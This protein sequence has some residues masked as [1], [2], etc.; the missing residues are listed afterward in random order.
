MK[1]CYLNLL[2]ILVIVSC[3]LTACEN[4]SGSDYLAVKITGD[5]NWSILDVNS[6]EFIYRDE[7]KNCPSVIVDNLFFVEKDKGNGY[8]CYNVTN[9]SNPINKEAYVYASNFRDGVA[10]VLKKG[11]PISIINAMGQEVK[12]LDKKIVNVFP[13]N[14]GFS[15]VI[16]KDGK[17]GVI[18]TKG[19]WAIKADYEGIIPFSQDGFAVTMK[20]QNDTLYNYSI[21]DAHGQKYYS[22]S[23]EK[24]EP[25]GSIVNGSM[26]VRKDNRVIYIDKNGERILE[27]G[28]FFKGSEISYGMYNGVTVYASNDAKMGLMNEKGEKLIRDKYDFI[29]PQKDGKFIVFRDGKCGLIDKDDN[30]I[31]PID[32][33]NIQKLK[34]NRYVVREGENKYSLI[35]E[36]GNE[37]CKETLASISLYKEAPVIF[38]ANTRM[39]TFVEEEILDM[40]R[41]FD[42]MMDELEIE[43]GEVPDDYESLPDVEEDKANE[44]LSALGTLR[45]KGIVDRYPITIEFT[46]KGSQVTGNLYYDRQ[47]PSNRLYFKGTNRNGIVDL[48]ETDDQSNFTGKFHGIL[49]SS[50]FSGEYT[51]AK[52][53]TMQA[54]ANR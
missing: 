27:A 20:K 25:I 22:F 30:T 41:S 52:G 40:T 19:A 33:Y 38:D 45:M 6:G 1:K 26:P 14:N 32:Y 21:V 54:I 3:F 9:I 13:F 44:D 37:I 48:V 50:S 24:Y 36:K 17:V 42:E 10:P 49:T 31:L 43:N 5:K 29:I 23:S 46:V 51:T 4:N 28:M 8:E 34:D 53:K 47:G 18:D 12:V 15:N 16:T 2:V 39:K 35:D 7:F 11:E